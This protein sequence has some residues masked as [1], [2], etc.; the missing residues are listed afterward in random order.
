MSSKFSLLILA[1]LLA[2]A[3]AFLSASLGVSEW[4]V[5]DDVPVPNSTST[6]RFRLGLFT[7]DSSTNGAHA[8][9]ALTISFLADCATNSA[10]TSDLQIMCKEIQA[11]RAFLFA[12]L[13]LAVLGVALAALLA[14]DRAKLFVLG[15]PVFTVSAFVC[16]AV[17]LGCGADAAVN[18][19][20]FSNQYPLKLGMSAIFCIVGVAAALAAA[21]VSVRWYWTEGRGRQWKTFKLSS[22]GSWCSCNRK[23]MRTLVLNAALSI[24]SLALMI[25]SL[26]VPQ[27]GS[28]NGFYYEPSP[29][30]PSSNYHL[31]I[32]FGA[33]KV[34]TEQFDYSTSITSSFS[35][36]NDMDCAQQKSTGDTQV[37][38]QEALAMQAFGI[39]AVIVMGVGLIL[40]LVQ[41]LPVCQSFGDRLRLY[42]RWLSALFVT[43]S[44]FG[45]I[46]LGCG[47]KAVQLYQ[48]GIRHL[49]TV[50]ASMGFCIASIVGMAAAAYVHWTRPPGPAERQKEDTGSGGVKEMGGS[51]SMNPLNPYR[52][53]LDTLVHTQPQDQSHGQTPRA[54]TS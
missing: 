30:G 38:C 1:A 15:L 44:V 43:S 8:S 39:M 14:S 9:I 18:R 16:S 29:I 42:P 27:W 24:V 2:I 49:L 11:A 35:N 33:F 3:I 53:Q 46:V 48:V 22:L 47:I 19:Y 40:V 5:A 37:S 36:A 34:D 52:G 51:L 10:F 20:Y 45:C 4:G 12:A 50:G 26:T 25:A 32:H 31:T 13:A 41:L 28:F 6:L 23:P 7:F 54:D 17:G 21:A